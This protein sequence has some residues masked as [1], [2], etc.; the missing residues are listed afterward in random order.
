MQLRQG[1]KLGLS[2]EVVISEGAYDRI[3]KS[4]EMNHNK[5]RFINLCFDHW[6]I[7]TIQRNEAK[8]AN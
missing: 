5:W 3:E 4:F 2:T 8:S 7:F 1:F 6:R